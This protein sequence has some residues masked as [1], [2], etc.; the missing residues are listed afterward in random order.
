MIVED[1]LRLAE[2]T[3]DYLQANGLRVDIEGNGAL[4]AARIIKEQPDLVILDLMLPGEDGLSICS[5][6]RSQF[7]GPILMLTARTDDADQIQGLDLGADDYVCKPVRP[8]LLLARIQALLRRSDSAEPVAEKN[9]RLQFGPLVVDSAL[10]EAW[11]SDSGIE[12]TSAE[13]DLLWLLVANAGRILSREEIFTAL[14]GIGYDG[15][16]RS[17]DVRISRI[18][19]KIGDDPDHPRLIKTIRSKGYLF[20]PEACADLSL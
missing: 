14:R 9:R 19:P 11:L 16:D 6:V 17:I 4:A 7:D 20:V 1:D 13:F 15:Q 3:R 2:L 8:R 18:R 5:K 10:R 12:L